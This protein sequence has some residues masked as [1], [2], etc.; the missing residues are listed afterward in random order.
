MHA[1][2]CTTM[3]QKALLVLSMHSKLAAQPDSVVACMHAEPGAVL[4]AWPVLPSKDQFTKLVATTI[5]QIFSIPFPAFKVSRNIHPTFFEANACQPIFAV[6]T[7][8]N[9]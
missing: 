2:L 5:V 4:C 1:M 6:Q 9:T 7:S 8:S 3:I